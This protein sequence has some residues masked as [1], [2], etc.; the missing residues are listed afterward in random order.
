MTG[1]LDPAAETEVE[2]LGL[3]GVVGK[4]FDREVLVELLAT[5]GPDTHPAD[6]PSPDIP[7]SSP[8]S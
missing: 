3:R 1:F 7:P 6:A 5:A 8:P 4:P 2:R